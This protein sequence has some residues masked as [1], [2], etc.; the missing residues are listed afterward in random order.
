MATEIRYIYNVTIYVYI[1]INGVVDWEIICRCRISHC[2]F[3][4]QRVCFIVDVVICTFF[5]G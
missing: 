4:Y 3:D 1:H 2:H 5:L